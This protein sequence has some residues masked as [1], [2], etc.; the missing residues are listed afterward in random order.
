MQVTKAGFVME[1]S[2][3]VEFNRDKMSRGKTEIGC[4][5]CDEDIFQLK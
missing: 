4:L 1:I 3:K 5:W 2:Y